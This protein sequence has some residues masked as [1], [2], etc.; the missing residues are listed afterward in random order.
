MLFRSHVLDLWKINVKD[1]PHASF[2]QFERDQGLSWP[3]NV[4]KG[5]FQEHFHRVDVTSNSL[6]HQVLPSLLSGLMRLFLTGPTAAGFAIRR[7]GV[8]FHAEVT[9]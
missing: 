5:R 6:A 3:G 7:F 1:K 8:D 2:L 4:R 9:H